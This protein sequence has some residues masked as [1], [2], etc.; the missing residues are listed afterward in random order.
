MYQS[1]LTPLPRINSHQHIGGRVYGART[2]TQKHKHTNTHTHTQVVEVG[3]EPHVFMGKNLLHG[4]IVPRNSGV[5]VPYS[6]LGAGITVPRNSLAN[7]HAWRTQGQFASHELVAATP[8]PLTPHIH[9]NNSPALPRP[10]RENNGESERRSTVHTH[11]HTHTPGSS[12]GELLMYSVEGAAAVPADRES[13]RQSERALLGTDMF[14]D[15][16]PADVFGLTHTSGNVRVAGLFYLY[17]RSLYS[18]P[19]LPI[20]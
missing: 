19:R 5:I 18:R 20:R 2:H 12:K 14:A 8:G 15:G 13:E 16:F 4:V 1:N 3:T 7:G 11:T 6:S 17:I 9:V 10:M